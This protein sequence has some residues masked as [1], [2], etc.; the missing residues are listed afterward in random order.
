M[1]ER[2]HFEVTTPI[3]ELPEEVES[4]LGL[5]DPNSPDIEFFNLIDDFVGKRD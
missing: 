4:P 2:K 5:Y 3:P 1:D